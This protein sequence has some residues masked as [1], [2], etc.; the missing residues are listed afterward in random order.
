MT[1]VTIIP[2]KRPEEKFPVQFQFADQLQFG[3]TISGQVCTCVVFQGEDANPS[4]VLF[5][6]PTLS[7]TVVSQVVQGGVAGVVYVL[8][9]AASGSTGTIYTKGGPLAILSDPQSFT[10]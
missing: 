6:S 9:C 8:T 2:S 4:A 1:S 5:G 7:G 10:G 3:E